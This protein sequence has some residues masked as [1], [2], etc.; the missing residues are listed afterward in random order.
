MTLAL[1]IL[2][3]LVIL[4]LGGFVCY[5]AGREQGYGD[6]FTEGYG[7]GYKD[8]QWWK[9]IHETAKKKIG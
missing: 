1:V 9:V 8:G 2:L 3:N 4:G 6:G 7:D 5:R